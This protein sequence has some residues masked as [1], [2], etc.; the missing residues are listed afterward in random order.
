MSNGIKTS[1]INK[2]TSFL[3]LLAFNFESFFDSFMTSVG[4]RTVVKGPVD[5]W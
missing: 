2:K 5:I 4:G 1:F 3:I